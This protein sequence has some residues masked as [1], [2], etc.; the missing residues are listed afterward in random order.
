MKALRN[1][2]LLI[3]VLALA[4]ALCGCALGGLGSI[5]KSPVL[6][7]AVQK[8]AGLIKDQPNVADASLERKLR[9]KKI[10]KDAALQAALE[11]AGVTRDQVTDVDIEL[12]RTLRSTWYEVDFEVM[13]TDYE[14]KIDAYTG[15]ILSLKHD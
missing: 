6:Q 3:L 1:T 4:M 8:D 15:E 5:G 11:D 12:R 13:L 7:T 2:V 14:Y 10:G 9:S